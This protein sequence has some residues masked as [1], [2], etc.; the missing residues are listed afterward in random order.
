MRGE[1]AAIDKKQF[2]E[3][4]LKQATEWDGK[5]A[6]E[7]IPFLSFLTPNLWV[8]MSNGFVQ[9]LCFCAAFGRKCGIFMLGEVFYTVNFRLFD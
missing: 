6:A 5:H 8:N 4:L 3:M 7:I 1:H 2:L 9:I